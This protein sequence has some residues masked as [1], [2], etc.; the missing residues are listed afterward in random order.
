MISVVVLA[1]NSADF[2]AECIA[3]VLNS[4]SSAIPVSTEVIVLDNGS[5]DDTWD[6]LT[7]IYEHDERVVLLHQAIGLGFAGGCNYAALYAHGEVLLFLNDDC[8]IESNCLQAIISE[9]AI[10]PEVGVVQC[11]VAGFDGSDW[12]TLGHFLDLWGF[13][14]LVVA[15]STPRRPIPSAGWWLF[16]ASG[17]ALAIRT[18]LFNELGGFDDDFQFLFEES[19][20]C[21]RALLLG[22]RV[23]GSGVAVVRHRQLARYR[24]R[25]HPS[26]FYLET[27]NRIRSISKNLEVWHA[28]VAIA[29]QLVLRTAFASERAICGQPGYI[30]DMVRAIVWNMRL[31]PRTW[32]MRR[33]IQSTRRVSDSELQSN[34]LL[35]RPT[36]QAAF[37]RRARVIDV[38]SLAR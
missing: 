34:G 9:L 15:P 1:F 4:T 22:A 32:H 8:V 30:V 36:L 10:S 24:S 25:G 7:R 6:V 33:R 20:L 17:A 27:R 13:L 12:D 18:A 3:S 19:D 21:W 37:G 26:P 28:I 31:A 2:V 16:G 5:S 38:E 23:I 14:H 11:A 29:V 35:L